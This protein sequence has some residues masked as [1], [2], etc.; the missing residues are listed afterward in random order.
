MRNNNRQAQSEI[1]SG[2]CLSP[3]LSRSFIFR[4]TAGITYA[5][6]HSRTA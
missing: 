6:A 2:M 4:I 5:A 3:F 1:H